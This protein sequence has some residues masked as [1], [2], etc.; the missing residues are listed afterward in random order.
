[1]MNFLTGLYALRW[2]IATVLAL[3]ILAFLA[4]KIFE[5]ITDEARARTKDLEFQVTRQRQEN[6]Q[7]RRE[8]L[9]ANAA[10]A[11]R[12]RLLHES[13]QL[14]RAQAVTR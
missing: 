4:V 13:E 7:L 12:T 3:A 14:R 8:L 6:L 2:P 1:M 5:F 11:S 10:I 9:H